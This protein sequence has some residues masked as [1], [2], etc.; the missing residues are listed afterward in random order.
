MLSVARIASRRVRGDPAA[1]VARDCPRGMCCTATRLKTWFCARAS[2]EKGTGSVLDGENSAFNQRLVAESGSLRPLRLK[3]VGDYFRVFRGERGNRGLVGS[4][5][6]G[7]VPQDAISL[8]RKDQNAAE[9]NGVR[10][11]RGARD[12]WSGQKPSPRRS[13]NC[14]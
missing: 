7:A 4:E 10:L 8:S 12:M 11:Q 5:I 2:I 1:T 3:K 13:P 9:R 14:P 6:Q